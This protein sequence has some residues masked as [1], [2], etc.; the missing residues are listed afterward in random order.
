VL[1]GALLKKAPLIAQATTQPY[2]SIT[3]LQGTTHT[4]VNTNI[5]VTHIPN[6]LL[7]KTGYTDL[8][9]G[10]LVVVYDAAINHPV[11]IVV[12]G[13]TESGRFSDVQQLMNATLAHFAGIMPK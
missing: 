3:S 6:P 10:N 8:A 1:A 7:S 4:F 5:D 13:S 12:L 9:G 11:A 2:I